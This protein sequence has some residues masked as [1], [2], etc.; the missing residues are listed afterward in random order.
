MTEISKKA[1]ITQ[2]TYHL[3][4]GNLFSTV[5]LALTSI[6]VGRLLGPDRFGLYT[7][8]LI[9]PTYVYLLLVWGL[10]ST[11]TRYSSKY[12]SEGNEKKAVSFGY[13]ISI[14]QL[15][16]GLLAVGLLIPFSNVISTNLL[17]RPELS[18]GIVIPVAIVS[19]VGQIMFYN[20][21]A[22]FV[23][24]HEFGKS[25]VFQII[26]A[27]TKLVISVLLIL[28]GYS[29]LGATAGYTFGY[30]VAGAIALI[31]LLLRNK[32]L[33]PSSIKE[34]VRTSIKY[35]PPVY[36][37]LLIAGVVFPVQNTMLAYVV[38]NSA[39][40]GYTAAG[41]IGTLISL[42]TIPIATTLLPLFSKT[43]YRGTAQLADTFKLSIK[44]AA[45]FILPV[46]M[47]VMAFSTP[48]VVAIYG[49]AYQFGGNYLV[50]VAMAS[51]LAGAGSISD[52]PFLYGIGET[53]KAFVATLIGA[54]VSISTSVIL[55]IHIGV[56]GI[57]I[58]TLL[59]QLLS[60]I[61]ALKFISNILGVKAQSWFFWRIY[62][63]S[64]LSAIIV[65]PI[66][67]IKL[68]P[69]LMVP[70]GGALF[71]VIIIPI[72]TWTKAL[73][74]DDMIEL[75]VQFKGV[76]SLGYFLKLITKYQSISERQSK[77]Q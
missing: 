63:S 12:L 23:G 36:Y 48:L 33:I 20:G 9:V 8:A 30:I 55:A 44:Y 42:F 21:S 3:F 62:L 43:V 1:T 60:L 45:L 73:T 51:L 49:Y 34:D 40:G 13:A 68:S 37:S 64:A 31:L 17:H 69:F 52:T 35:A 58:G 18:V 71:L 47:F 59:G 67:L 16:S 77:T 27:F 28:L 46:A 15:A 2:G 22:A 11:I 24:L 61:V 75:Q 39:I 53:R 50:I 4:I 14:L 26:M 29:V 70:F 32:S 41:N 56:Y 72:M 5:A 7:I 25:A 74:R 19:V 10:P 57:L 6:V 54:A 38:S 66:S 65:Y 76:K